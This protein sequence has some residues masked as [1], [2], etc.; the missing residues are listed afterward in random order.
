MD[1]PMRFAIHK[2]RILYYW[3]LVDPDLWTGRGAGERCYTRAHA[4]RESARR[5]AKKYNCK[6]A[7][8]E[9]ER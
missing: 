6:V 7:F 9:D 1:K 4:A 5:F 2:G 8:V 3:E